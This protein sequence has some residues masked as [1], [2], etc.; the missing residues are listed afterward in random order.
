MK[1][2]A[3]GTSLH[4]SFAS[5]AVIATISLPL[6]ENIAKVTAVL[7]G[8]ALACCETGC[9]RWP[10][11]KKG[12]EGPCGSSNAEV[13]VIYACTAQNWGYGTIETGR[14]PTRCE[15]MRCI[16]WR[17]NSGEMIGGNANPYSLGTT[18]VSDQHLQDPVSICTMTKHHKELTPNIDNQNEDTN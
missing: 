17:I 10:Y 3:R 5:P 14:F 1:D 12:E 15:S 9:D 11:I 8:N 16:V 4:G 2:I 7:F 18:L 13:S 6:H